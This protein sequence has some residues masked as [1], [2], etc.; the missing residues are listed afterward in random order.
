M[1]AARHKSESTIKTHLYRA[2]DKLTAMAGELEGLLE[3]A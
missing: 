2:L 3:G 1:S